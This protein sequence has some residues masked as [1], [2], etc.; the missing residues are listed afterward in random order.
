MNNAKEL[1]QEFADYIETN[2]DEIMALSIFY[3]Q[4][5]RRRDLT[6]AMVKELLDTLKQNKPRIAPHN[7]WQAYQQLNEVKVLVYFDTCMVSFTV[8]LTRAGIYGVN[9]I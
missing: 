4:P 2:K 5:Y 8:T 1:V 6:Y 3:D 7:V 9:P